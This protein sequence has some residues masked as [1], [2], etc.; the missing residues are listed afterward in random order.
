MQRY[1]ITEY[2]DASP[3]T[4]AVYDDYLRTTG[5]TSLPV[6]IKS[7]GHNASI[8][9]AYWEKGKG[10]LLGGKLPLPLKELIVFMVSGTNEAK[11]C[12]ACHAQ[13]ILKLDKTL[14]IEDLK[15]FLK[16]EKDLPFP[17]SYKS[18]LNFAVKVVKDPNNV[19]DKDFEE[20]IDEGFTKEEICEII[21]IVDMSTMF[22]IY[23][24]ALKLHLDPHYQAIL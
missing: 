22:N 18:V 3:E 24:S 16:G 9:K 2:E 23:T 1:I 13:A 12:T 14:T 17:K 11:Y 20:L 10:T 7:M 5:S 15:E 21:A 8:A 4:K 6:W 19:D